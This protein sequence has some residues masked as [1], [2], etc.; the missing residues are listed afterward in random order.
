MKLKLRESKDSKR[1]TESVVKPDSIVVMNI[2]DN[3]T[4]ISDSDYDRLYDITHNGLMIM[5][6]NDDV[7]FAWDAVVESITNGNM[8]ITGDFGQQGTHDGKVEI[9]LPLSKVNNY[10]KLYVEVIDDTDAAEEV[11]KI[12]TDAKWL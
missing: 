1:L 4:S 9:T 5:P 2:T 7:P 6:K 12:F 10:Y 3:S 8:I 11:E